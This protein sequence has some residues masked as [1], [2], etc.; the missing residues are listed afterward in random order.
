MNVCNAVHVLALPRFSPTV[1]AVLP[2]YDPENVSVPL[3]AVRSARL[4]PREIPEI[5]EFWRAEFGTLDTVSMLD[6]FDSP[7]P[8]R[9]TNVCPPSIRLVVEAVV[10][11]PYVVDEYESVVSAENTFGP[12]NVF[13][14]DSSVVEAVESVPVIVTGAEPSTVKPAHDTDPEQEAVVVAVVLS[15]P[16]EPTYARP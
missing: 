14:S 5:V 8:S 15:S 4:E 13:E 6:E 2:L 1:L 16:V 9:P 11:D 10:K 3:V 7:V 12:E